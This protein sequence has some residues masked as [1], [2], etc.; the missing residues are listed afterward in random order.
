MTESERKI[1][2]VDTG[3]MTKEEIR[4]HLEGELAKKEEARE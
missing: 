2:Y 3:D 4:K 1:F